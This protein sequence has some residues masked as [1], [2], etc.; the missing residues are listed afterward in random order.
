MSV[1]I[2]QTVVIYCWAGLRLKKKKSWL[3]EDYN[4]HSTPNDT[5]AGDDAMSAHWA[6]VL[7]PIEQRAG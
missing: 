7:K 4:M 2:L 5:I 6:R 3:N 1:L